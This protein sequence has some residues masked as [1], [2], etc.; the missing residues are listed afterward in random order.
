MFPLN[1]LTKFLCTY[2]CFEYTY[3]NILF[4]IA[5]YTIVKLNIHN[6]WNPIDKWPFIGM[7][8]LCDSSII[9]C[10]LRFRRMARLFAHLNSVTLNFWPGRL[11]V[12]ASGRPKI[13]AAT[14]KTKNNRAPPAVPSLNH[15]S[16][17]Y[18]DQFPS[19]C[20]HPR[21]RTHLYPSRHLPSP[22]PPYRLIIYLNWWQLTN[23]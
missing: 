3:N 23:N 16:R 8:N 11:Q 13:M 9:E 20:L 18:G 22:L 21:A 1:V 19:L 15:R 4:L 17:Y 12:A 6:H 10:G 14:A 2:D 5:D 7:G